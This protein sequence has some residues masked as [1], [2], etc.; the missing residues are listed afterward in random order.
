MTDNSELLQLIHSLPPEM[1]E[2]IEGVVKYEQQLREEN[3]RL[4]E[5]LKPFADASASMHSFTGQRYQGVDEH[6]PIEQG[7]VDE[8]IMND[9]GVGEI[10]VA[11]LQQA[12][13]VLSEKPHEP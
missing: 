13:A 8:A 9:Y 5:A 3:Q 6:L 1:Q 10:T 11:N 7:I 12:A 2:A 4:R